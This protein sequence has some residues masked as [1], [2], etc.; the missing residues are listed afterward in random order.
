M[1]P[2]TKQKFNGG[3]PLTQRNK[4]SESIPPPPNPGCTKLE[5]ET[6]GRKTRNAE[7]L[8]GN[9]RG[10]RN[11]FREIRTKKDDYGRNREP[12]GAIANKNELWK[13]CGRGFL[14]PG[15]DRNSREGLN[16]VADS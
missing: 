13:A 1:G 16:E 4:N 10:H 8:R 12:K 2:P 6:G 3:L 14:R 7:N 9:R 5:P 11:E 15:C